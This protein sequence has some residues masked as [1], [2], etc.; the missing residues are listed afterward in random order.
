MTAIQVFL[1]PAAGKRLIARA[2]AN[3][4][5]VQCAAREHTVV[6]VE[7]STNSYLAAELLKTLGD[8]CFELRGFYRGLLKPA[9]AQRTVKPRDEDV[10]ICKGVLEKG[11]TIFDAAEQLGPQDM[12]FKGANAVC[13]ADGTAGVI[14]GN[15]TSGTVAPIAAAVLGRR[16]RLIH[17]VGVEKRV[18][19]P[20]H[21]LAEI[22][23]RAGC[24]GFRLYPS[25]GRAYTEL[26]ALREMCGVQAHIMAGGGVGGY[27]GGCY[28]LCEGDAE[29]LGKCRAVTQELADTPLYEL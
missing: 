26:D 27:E 13:L 18:E 4:P 10:V 7:G 20:I 24:A 29:S 23:N 3:R 21:A 8:D 14:I 28:F 1:T 17:P 11:K 15:P 2:L 25:P 9:K 22:C 19:E 16:T 6:I 12:I 5:D